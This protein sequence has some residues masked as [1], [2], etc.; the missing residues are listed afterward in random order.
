M[1]LK[2]EH[3]KHDTLTEDVFYPDHTQRTESPTF[4]K[5][6]AVGHK[7]KLPCS[8]SGH[9]DGTEYHHVFLEWAFADGVDWETVK[10]VA[11]G[12][13]TELPV[14]D[15]HTDQP[16]G[17][18]YPAKQSLIWVITTLTEARGF[19]WEAF[20][21]AKPET[22]VDDMANMLVLHSKFHRL[23]DHGIHVM[24]FPEWCFQAWPRKAGFV[25]TPDEQA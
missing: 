15:L 1:D 13:I 20:D 7:A 21:P 2:N 16:T 9:V 19:D 6:K 23:K 24:S 14:L 10:G 8:I 22:F 18:M 4:L 3:E 11:T 17:E 25:F 5:T 12:K